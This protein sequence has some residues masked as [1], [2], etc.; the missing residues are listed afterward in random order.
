M[1]RSVILICIFNF[2]LAIGV[3]W[4][5]WNPSSKQSAP[6]ITS[7]TPAAESNVTYSKE[8]LWTKALH[9]RSSN[10]ALYYFN[11]SDD[12]AELRL[13]LSDIILGL[14]IES[15]PTSNIWPFLQATFYLVANEAKAIEALAPFS[16]ITRKKAL[17]LTIRDSAF[18]TYVENEVRLCNH[19]TISENALNLID[20]LYDEHNSLKSSALQAEHFLLSK[21]ILPNNRLDS[22]NRR[23]AETVE[24]EEI[25]LSTRVIALNILATMD[26][27]SSIALQRVYESAEPNFRDALLKAMIRSKVAPTSLSWLSDFKPLSVDEEQLLQRVLR[28]Y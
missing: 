25:L 6:A 18:R 17:P 7:N 11:Q 1:K 15:P 13:K 2:C 26:N 27:I 12:P 4:Y 22:Y 28:P 10:E 5:V 16:E 9:A 24:N 20:A 19:E 14:S 21:G 8:E 3:L 23:L